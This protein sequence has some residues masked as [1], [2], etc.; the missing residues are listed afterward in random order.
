MHTEEQKHK[1]MIPSHKVDT[2]RMRIDKD[3]LPRQ[4]ACCVEGVVV[5]LSVRV[6]WD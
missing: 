3:T 5:V 2:Q 4:Y 6:D 1:E